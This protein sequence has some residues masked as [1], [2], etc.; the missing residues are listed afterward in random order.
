[1]QTLWRLC[2]HYILPKSTH[3]PYQYD[4]MYPTIGTSAPETLSYDTFDLHIRRDKQ[5]N[6]TEH[7]PRKANRDQIEK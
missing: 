2:K 3:N 4:S 1:M 5:R 6:Y 7:I